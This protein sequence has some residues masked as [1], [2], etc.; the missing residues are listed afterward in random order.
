VPAYLSSLLKFFASS[1]KPFMALR[2]STPGA[3]CGEANVTVGVGF[4][5]SGDEASAF[6]ISFKFARHRGPDESRCSRSPWRWSAADSTAD[7]DGPRTFRVDVEALR[8]ENENPKARLKAVEGGL[9]SV[10]LRG[11]E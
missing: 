6:S 10:D 3:L 8:T 7:G 1:S 5:A 9:S 11:S 2:G 4:G